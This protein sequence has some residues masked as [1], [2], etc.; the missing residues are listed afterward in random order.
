M[1]VAEYDEA[2]AVC[3][4]ITEHDHQAGI[5]GDTVFNFGFTVLFVMWTN[6]VMHGIGCC[7]ALQVAGVDSQGLPVMNVDTVTSCM[8]RLLKA[9]GL[10]RRDNL[11]AVGTWS[12]SRDRIVRLF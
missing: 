5:S 2:C 6:G 7:F 9:I 12:R 1:E 3:H 4:V 10:L 8:T 11:Q